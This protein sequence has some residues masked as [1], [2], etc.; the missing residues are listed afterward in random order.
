MVK[1]ILFFTCLL[2]REQF[3]R[4]IYKSFRKTLTS[5]SPLI[6]SKVLFR[7]SIGEKLDLKNPKLFDEKLMW[8]KLNEDDL[9][10]TKGADK[11]QVREY[12]AEK[13]YQDI[14]NKL[15]F[16]YEEVEDINFDLLP[17]SF[18]LKCT[19]GVA[20]HIICSDKTKLDRKK[21]INKL[22]QWLETDYSLMSAEP[23]YKNIK[24]RIIAEKYLGN[25]KGL[26]P[27]DY[28]IHCFNGNPK[29]IEVVVDRTTGNPKF[30]FLDLNWNLLP[31]NEDSNNYKDN[32]RQPK[33]ISEMLDISK[34]L[35]EDFTYV[36]LNNSHFF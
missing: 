16:V 34:K 1:N 14:L 27:V 21:A 2:D 9:L 26:V 36:S 7:I 30:L 29:I 23:H 22:S 35:S 13:G 5:I 11:Y 15:Y 17:N 18:V 12:V 25:K 8:L 32:I 3:T 20:C 19:H 24:P 33:K 10:K 31:Y 28:K 4:R 6:A